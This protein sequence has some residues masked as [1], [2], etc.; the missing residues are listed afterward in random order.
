MRVAWTVL[1]SA[2]ILPLQLSAQTYRLADGA[3]LRYLESG[4]SSTRFGDPQQNNIPST[5]LHEATIAIAADGSRGWVASYDDLEVRIIELA[6]MIAPEVDFK[7]EGAFLL[8]V[9][10][11]GGIRTLEVP[12]IPSEFRALYN[13]EFQFADFF[14]G[15]PEDVPAL[16]DT[17][18]DTVDVESD[19]TRIRSVRTMRVV[20]DTVVDGV[21]ATVIDI[22]AQ[23][24]IMSM[25]PVRGWDGTP[26]TTL[27]GTESGTAIFD[28]ENG[29]M[30]FRS[31]EVEMQGTLSSQRRGE[32]AMRVS[33]NTSITLSR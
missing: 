23:P 21:P 31:R 26:T 25:G 18:T 30:L 12:T 29:V 5:L 28:F 32:A 15:L 33:F 13:P 24:S 3:T 20:G 27:A 9:L 14:I 1:F 6:G 7:S 10:P 11:S 19:S 4:R 8:D 22:S 2:I 16:G 17:W